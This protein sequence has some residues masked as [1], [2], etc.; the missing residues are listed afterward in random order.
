[1]SLLTLSRMHW[2]T[3]L[4]SP[5]FVRSS[6]Y[7]AK[8]LRL[9]FI[10]FQLL[11]VV[12]FIHSQDLLL[13]NLLPE[14]ILFEDDL[15]LR[16]DPGF[17]FE[18]C[19]VAL[20]QLDSILYPSIPR[21]IDD[22][23][24]TTS[25]W[26]LGKISTF[27]YLMAIN[28]AVGR[29]LT[30]HLYH[31]LFP[32]VTNFLCDARISSFGFR[33]LS[34]TKFRL[35][36]GDAQ[37]ESTY[38]HSDPPHHIPESMSELTYFIYLARKTPLHVLRRVVRDVFVPEHYPHNM[39]RMFEWTPDECI[40]EFYYDPGV[41]SSMHTALGL[42]DVELPLFAPDP[43]SFISYH[44]SILE[45]DFV[46]NSIHTWID[47]TFGYCLEGSAAI[48][49]L[50][51][52]LRPAVK[53]DSSAMGVTSRHPGF[54]I[55]F[56]KPHPRRKVA[57]LAQLSRS[58]PVG[59]KK[60]S[61][62]VVSATPFKPSR[63]NSIILQTSIVNH[64]S[65]MLGDLKAFIDLDSNVT[66]NTDA[67]SKR[68][69]ERRMNTSESLINS[70][71]SSNI[72]TSSGVYT[73]IEGSSAR[74]PISLSV[75]YDSNPTWLELRQALDVDIRSDRRSKTDRDSLNKLVL[76]NRFGDEFANF[77]D[78]VYHVFCIDKN[79]GLQ[80]NSV[81][82]EVVPRWDNEFIEELKNIFKFDISDNSIN[83]TILIKKLQELDM[84]SLACI[85][86]ELYLGRPLLSRSNLLD[87]LSST[88][89]NDV[90]NKVS[91]LIYNTVTI[92]TADSYDNDIPVPLKRLL[93]ILIVSSVSNVMNIKNNDNL[94]VGALE[95]LQGCM[96]PDFDLW[97]RKA[98]G[99]LRSGGSICG[100]I[101]FQKAHQDSSQLNSMES[102]MLIDSP[103]GSKAPTNSL[104]A[105]TM[106][107]I[108]ESYCSSLFPAYFLLVY[109]FI[110]SMKLANS[111]I[112][113]FKIIVS[114]LNEFQ[115]MVSEGLEFA[116]PH[117]FE[118]LSDSSILQN[119]SQQSSLDSVIIEYIAIID[120]IGQ[121]LGIE[122]TNTRMILHIVKFI[123][124]SKS[125]HCL[126]VLL[127][128][129][130]WSVI[131]LRSGVKSFLFHFFPMLLTFLLS[132]VL[133][134][135]SQG[136]TF[137]YE[138]LGNISIVTPLWATMGISDKNEWLHLCSKEDIRDI[139]SASAL[140]IS[141]LLD[142][143]KL[144]L[145]LSSRYIIPTL[146]SFVGNPQLSSASICTKSS[147]YKEIWDSFCKDIMNLN[148]EGNDNDATKLNQVVDSIDNYLYE[149]TSRDTQNL[150]IVNTLIDMSS[151]LGELVCSELI[152]LRIFDEILP[153][154]EHAF[155]IPI[156][157]PPTIA[158]LIEIIQL[159]NGLFPNLSNETIFK[160]CIQGVNNSKGGYT[161]PKLLAKI[162]FNPSWSV[163]DDILDN[164]DLCDI[165]VYLDSDRKST[166]MLNLVRLVVT[167][168]MFIGPV[169]AM[170][171][172]L[173]YANQFF[174]NFIENFQNQN[175]ES[176]VM[177]KAFEIASEL[178][179]PLLQLSG[180]KFHSIV[181]S[182]NPR[183]E[184][185]LQ[186]FGS[187]NS[188]FANGCRRT[189]PPLPSSILPIQVATTNIPQVEQK[190]S[191]KYLFSKLLPSSRKQLTRNRESTT[192]LSSLS[193]QSKVADS[194]KT[195]NIDSTKQ[196]NEEANQQDK[197]SEAD[198]PDLSPVAR[199][200]LLSAKRM[201]KS[202]KKTPFTDGLFS[203][204][205]AM[206]PISTVDSVQSYQSTEGMELQVQGANFMSPLA[207]RVLE[208]EKVEEAIDEIEIEDNDVGTA[209]EITTLEGSLEIDKDT[210]PNDDDDEGLSNIREVNT[211]PDGNIEQYHSALS[212]TIPSLFMTEFISGNIAA[213][214]L[215][216][217]KL[218]STIK[219]KTDIDG[220]Q[221]DQYY[222]DL[223]WLMSGI[224]HRVATQST[225]GRQDSVS[226]QSIATDVSNTPS[227]TSSYNS[228]TSYTKNA[229]SLFSRFGTSKTSTSVPVSQKSEKSSLGVPAVQLSM[230]S[231]KIN[232]D[233]ASESAS[234]FNF[235]MNIL[236]SWKADESSVTSIGQNVSYSSQLP[237]YS[238]AT[239]AL[240]LV[241]SKPIKTLVV[242]PS[243]SLVLSCSS[244]GSK[245]WSLNCHPVKLSAL[246]PNTST[247]IP[248]TCNFLGSGTHFATCDGSIALWD[249][250]SSRI[251]SYIGGS[252]Q[253]Q[254]PF[255]TMAVIP[256]RYGISPSI[257][258][259]GD[260]Q[261]L[262][263]SNGF[264]LSHYDFRSA[265]LANNM[266]CISEISL[267][268]PITTLTDVH[269]I[270]SLASHEHYIY[271]GSNF[272]NLFL[273]DRRMG[274]VIGTWQ[275]HDTN[276][277]KLQVLENDSTK[278]I[279]VAEKSAYIWSC[280]HNLDEQY[281]RRVAIFKNM[282]ESNSSL[283]SSNTTIIASFDQNSSSNDIFQPET[284]T[285]DPRNNVN[286]MYAFAGHKM[287]TG[288][289][290]SPY[291]ST[292][293]EVSL[294]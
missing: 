290:N 257:N 287:Y 195:K 81:A 6:G 26:C 270:V 261:I 58:K 92:T 226:T 109:E 10:I 225:S 5:T 248:F 247:T 171:Y 172:V 137:Q 43:E 162:S 268:S 1:M 45:S 163:R 147:N 164:R 113:K 90:I 246:Y 279:S 9:R 152:L 70:Y 292:F 155:I 265:S 129:P 125:P 107:N 57:K 285:K 33:D 160:Y 150:T 283:L 190:K 273:I 149:E 175:V 77:F 48:S 191:R 194:L 256:S 97:S 196:I 210:D 106:V 168:S 62:N 86:A 274:S 75:A 211:V 235:N 17:S 66:H 41:F 32:W 182:I 242:H 11:Q 119:L 231:P 28:H 68:D 54:I 230:T 46:S 53:T 255:H 73:R 85:I 213:N 56:N 241:T 207:S 101:N 65:N 19:R 133:Q 88:S 18:A 104:I 217:G 34:K 193:S 76:D 178:Y 176:F 112:D 186:S 7:G 188:P 148:D 23:T 236:T 227:N 52:P 258:P 263:S 71:I 166:L 271:A 51:V 174:V 80:S 222:N 288:I 291:Y 40:P 200:A 49:N 55:L 102:E 24:T 122:E 156:Q 224:S 142:P 232:I 59:K 72:P 139:Q 154:L 228:T 264:T 161:L 177:E 251:I 266:K 144:G 115:L 118:V 96:S 215:N 61:N 229:Q 260:N 2:K 14:H 15:W 127:V 91:V 216:G 214:D 244:S 83:S 212:I 198:S 205:S 201:P 276:V 30:D 16:M 87:I 138:S 3:L 143:S 136:A 134:N 20:K 185:W 39:Q 105:S 60:S 82:Q 93:T 189:S 208:F 111:P 173:P 165:D 293:Y 262:T 184:E 67:K 180:S 234:Y 286:V 237:N 74:Q 27:E 183:L 272:G 121:R 221:D 209:D 103:F 13:N 179:Q 206:M 254:T 167:A 153:S 50:N 120:V 141:S 31:P 220:D 84:F 219:I 35:A 233:T 123:A 245:I 132:G 218:K 146:M 4:V 99:N 282:P 108:I 204:I 110:G 69:H 8:D 114:R 203:P 145:G 159:L 187:V 47:L 63:K 131:I 239:N 36:K 277:V 44:R 140:A 275:G 199:N 289:I 170:E 243:E 281:V 223:T 278:F 95:I 197:T 249:V 157:S 253:T 126:Q 202:Y 37:L 158:A 29:T 94:C 252:E 89:S 38:R 250:E 181:T 240:Q 151:R 25:R 169:Y 116:L 12:A 100:Y 269:S 21:C 238:A 42:S 259:C 192:S 124:Q 135:I 130:I 98:V 79:E 117:I 64:D 284:M 128:S 267:P 78:P 294:S 280:N 22:N